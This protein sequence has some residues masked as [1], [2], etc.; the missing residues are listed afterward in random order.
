MRAIR[1]CCAEF[2]VVS[3]KAGHESKPAI[4]VGVEGFRRQVALTLTGGSF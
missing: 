3:A 1:S 4:E 2:P